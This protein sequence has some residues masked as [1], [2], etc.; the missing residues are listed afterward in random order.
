MEPLDGLLNNA[1]ESFST[2]GERLFGIGWRDGTYNAP[3]AYPGLTGLECTGSGPTSHD[4]DTC[5]VHEGITVGAAYAG[6]RRGA[7]AMRERQ[8][9]TDY[10]I[11][12]TYTR[13]R[14]AA[15][16]PYGAASGETTLGV[17]VEY[18][19]QGD[20]NWHIVGPRTRSEPLTLPTCDACGEPQTMDGAKGDPS[21]WN[22][23]TGCHLT[24]EWPVH[25]V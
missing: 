24:C 22:P 16:R 4:G 11:F 10:P 3:S 8:F 5:P 7:N 12:A 21:D 23:E 14:D 18:T 20:A 19:L 2:I 17:P 9:A 25:D 15:G 1:D 13:E 6:A